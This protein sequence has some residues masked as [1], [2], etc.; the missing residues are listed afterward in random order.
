MNF[1]NRFI[2][3]YQA[4]LRKYLVAATCETAP[5]GFALATVSELSSE[6]IAARPPWAQ[7]RLD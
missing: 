4:A 7:A 3:D 1:E 6:T 5:A 2:P